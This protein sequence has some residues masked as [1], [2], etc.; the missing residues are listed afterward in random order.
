MLLSPAHPKE[1]V[2]RNVTL[3]AL[4]ACAI[5]AA[6]AGDAHAG[7]FGRRCGRSHYYPVCCPPMDC[8][9]PCGL[10]GMIGSGQSTNPDDVPEPHKL[11][12]KKI[13]DPL[14]TLKP[15]PES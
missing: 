7:L 4:T 3:S 11:Q 13:P 14:P 2:L 6:I 9:S 15:P 12:L 10:P 5:L 1:P 8:C